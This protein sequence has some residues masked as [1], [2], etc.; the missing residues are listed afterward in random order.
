MLIKSNRENAARNIHDIKGQF[1]AKKVYLPFSKDAFISELEV[2]KKIFIHVI[3]IIM[4]S[5]ATLFNS[6]QLYRNLISQK[7]GIKKLKYNWLKV[8]M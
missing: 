2:K 5:L 1:E 4:K 6:L 3:T 8:N 7:H